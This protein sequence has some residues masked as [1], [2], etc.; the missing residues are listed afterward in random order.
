M[1]ART[2][3]AAL[4]LS[5]LLV[6]AC[7]AQ[8]PDDGASVADSPAPPTFAETAT[9]L[10]AAANPRSDPRADVMAAT[11]RMLAASSYVADIET[12]AGTLK[13][14]HAAPHRFRMTMPD[15]ITQTIVDNRMYMQVQGQTMQMPLQEGMLEKMRDQ[16]RIAAA[17]E[18]ATFES[19]GT[20]S[21]EGKPARKYRVIHEDPANPPATLWI[22]SDGYPL[23]MQVADEAAQGAI[24]IRCSRFNDPSIVIEAP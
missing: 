18:R 12:G 17:R 24:T 2:P 13:L 11:E 4:A 22:G 5:V 6:G 19:L 14:E 23:R 15:G 8:P 10:A 7:T 21:V 16:G 3:A 20:D 1:P 9:R